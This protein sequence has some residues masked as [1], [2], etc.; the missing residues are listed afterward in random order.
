MKKDLIFSF[1]ASMLLFSF[2]GISMGSIHTNEPIYAGEEG[3]I[4]VNVENPS[5]S[6]YDD[7]VVRVFD[8]DTGD[9]ALTSSM[10]ISREGTEGRQISMDFMDRGDH[11]L[12]VVASNG[13][14]R[15]SKYIYFDVY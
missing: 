11:L 5:Y 9:Y 1:L 13:D 2:G 14:V 6:G 3:Q 7:I 8:M 12:K 10:D 4:F 15:S